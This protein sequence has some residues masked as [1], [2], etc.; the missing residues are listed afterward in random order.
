MLQR[1]EDDPDLPM[2]DQ[3]LARNLP[4]L[5][6]MNSK[7]LS[8]NIIIQAAIDHVLAERKLIEEA[9]PQLQDLLEEHDGLHRECDEW[10]T[11]AGLPCHPRDRRD[12]F[13]IRELFVV[14]DYA[15]GS[16][17]NGFSGDKGEDAA[18]NAGQAQDGQIGE[19]INSHEQFGQLFDGFAQPETTTEGN[20][21]QPTE[22]WQK[23]RMVPAASSNG[24]KKPLPKLQSMPSTDVGA[25][26]A[27]SV[28]HVPSSI[29]SSNRGDEPP[30]PQADPLV[31]QERE[32]A[33]QLRQEGVAEPSPYFNPD[34]YS[35]NNLH[36]L[37]QHHPQSAMPWSFGTDQ[38][39][40]ASAGQSAIAHS[41]G[42][43]QQQSGLYPHQQIAPRDDASTSTAPDGIAPSPLTQFFGT[44]STSTPDTH[45]PNGNYL[46]TT[47]FDSPFDASFGSGSDAVPMPH[48]HIDL[49][50]EA[51]RQFSE[52]IAQQEHHDTA[53]PRRDGMQQQYNGGAPR[54]QAQSQLPSPASTTSHTTSRTHASSDHQSNA[55]AGFPN[56]PQTSSSLDFLVHWPH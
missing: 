1:V 40:F 56:F 37:G 18:G 11:K 29:A 48:G 13:H 53:Q 7:R 54:S 55:T 50:R 12:E 19:E 45:P 24:Q 42:H 49:H 51:H 38:S 23:P 5:A 28:V 17:P 20:N 2:L 35:L 32:D 41:A 8:K 25:F 47:S 31:D 9:L 46:F 33:S 10:R 21:A 36:Y 6:T 43:H 30:T 15:F 3:L 4:P 34:A 14:R 26:P 52:L 27:L 39:T 22:E 16:F 44:G